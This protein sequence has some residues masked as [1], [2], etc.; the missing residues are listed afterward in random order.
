M[1]ICFENL[2]PIKKVEINLADLTVLVGPQASGKSIA[3]QLLRFSQDYRYI[4]NTLRQ[5]GF[6]WKGFS[7][8]MELYLGEN[9]GSVWHRNSSVKVNGKAIK[10]TLNQ[11]YN[12]AESQVF[13]MPAQRVL[14][15]HEGWPRPFQSFKMSDPF[16]LKDFSE[17]IRQIMEK[18]LGSGQ[19]V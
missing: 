12:K 5:N 7:N 11:R 14:M 10:T 2:G 18:G 19:A 4:V 15:V 3:L 13:F 9:M 17:R 6:Q 16:V 1:N 8:L